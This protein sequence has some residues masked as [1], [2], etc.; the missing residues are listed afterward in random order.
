MCIANISRHV[1]EGCALLKSHD[2]GTGKQLHENRLLKALHSK[3][4]Q[5]FNNSPKEIEAFLVDN[6]LLPQEHSREE[7]ARQIRQINGINK[8]KLGQWL[9]KPGHEDIAKAFI[10]D[11]DFTGKRIDDAMRLMLATFRLPGE[12]QEINRIMEAFAPVLYDQCSSDPSMS[13]IFANADA[14]YIMAYSV[15]MLNTDQHNPQYKGRRMTEEDFIKNNRGNNDGR[16]YDHDF[17]RAVY[18][19]IKSNEILMPE[20]HEGDTA[21]NHRYSEI[22]SVAKVHY[23]GERLS[24]E[25]SLV[26]GELL[27]LVW[28]HFMQAATDCFESQL[29]QHSNDQKLVV[30]S[31]LSILRDLASSAASL[32][33]SHRVDELILAMWNVSHLEKFFRSKDGTF[34]V[35]VMCVHACVCVCVCV[36]NNVARYLAKLE[37]G[38]EL[39]RL[40]VDLFKKHG[41]VIRTG[42]KQLVDLVFILHESRVISSESFTSAPRSAE[43]DQQKRSQSPNSDS[44][45]ASLTSYLY[46]SESMPASPALTAAETELVNK[47]AEF[48]SNTCRFEDIFRESRMLSSDALSA[49]LS[50]FLGIVSPSVQ[51]SWS[52]ST[53]SLSIDICIYC[54]LQNRDRLGAV[55]SVLFAGLTELASRGGDEV[56]REHA[57]IGLGRLALKMAEREEDTEMRDNLLAF[58]QFLCNFDPEVFYKI[59]QP[60]L[61]IVLK[62]VELDSSPGRTWRLLCGNEIWPPY[63]TI[64]SLVSRHRPC[65]PYTLGLLMAATNEQSQP[66][67]PL[68]FFSEYLELL[69]AFIASCNETAPTSKLPV[70]F[71]DMAKTAMKRLSDLEAFMRQQQIGDVV[72]DYILPIHSAI[73]VQCCH[74]S[75]DIRQQAVVTLHKLVMSGGWRRTEDVVGEFN[76]VLFNLLDELQSDAV[77]SFNGT[78]EDTQMGAASLVSKVFL[79][80]VMLMQQGDPQ[81]LTKILLTMLGKLLGFLRFRSDTLR[82]GVPET[83]KN[84]LFVLSTTN[85]LDLNQWTEVWSLVDQVLPDLKKEL[86]HS[87]SPVVTEKQDETSSNNNNNNSNNHDTLP[88][89]SKATISNASDNLAIIQPVASPSAIHY[90]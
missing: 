28:E 12:S 73:A 59:A 77:L 35:V 4:A 52:R 53:R 5:V 71:V 7:L 87:S 19:S 51:S 22:V 36:G 39:I 57:V 34:L 23:P 56:L 60:V 30:T 9:A 17:L 10:A 49:M 89:T 61:A 27:P 6:N 76:A 79:N 21:F 69:S 26:A 74:P 63:F 47:V 20:E 78:I 62:I 46:T 25:I 80:N 65:A 85:A 8:K 38:R 82:E 45:L 58:L 70:S 3:A 68:D 1:A 50:G 42:W 40:L 16:D 32:N 33:Q 44:I 24:V 15:I 41:E 2:D 43:P 11:L 66:L 67:F 83:V 18:Q 72:F 81:T 86:G 48:L 84:I 88:D 54:A 64:M 31:V 90:V 55:W 29:L 75:R 13:A 37:S 14:V